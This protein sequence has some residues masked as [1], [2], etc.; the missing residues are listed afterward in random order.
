MKR[1]TSSKII[2]VDLDGPLADLEGEFLARWKKKF[3]GEFFVPF[4]KRKTFFLREEYPD[5]LKPKTEAVLRES[6]FFADL[7]IVPGSREALQTLHDT[8]YTIIICTADIIANPTGLADKRQWVRKYLGDDF[9]KG[10]I[11]THDK[12]L[13]RGDYLI[14]DK[15]LIK[16]ALEPSWEHVIF[17][18]PFNRDVTDKKRMKTDWSNWKELFT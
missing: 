5:Y 10:M 3:P 1:H 7:P 9:A 2:L 18:Q 4:E 14:D 16:G 15:P 11:F 13:I 6:G 12:T 8:G 17:D